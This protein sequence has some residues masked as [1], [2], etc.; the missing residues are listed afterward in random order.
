MKNQ[1]SFKIKQKI[2]EPQKD[3]YN[4]GPGSYDIPETKSKIGTRFS[5]NQHKSEI[6]Q[7]RAEN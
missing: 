4:T 2:P 6:G 1:R 7:A 3:V 5:S